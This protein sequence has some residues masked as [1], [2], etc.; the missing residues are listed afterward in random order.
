VVPVQLDGEVKPECDPTST[1]LKSLSMISSAF[2]NFA[3]NVGSL[4]N[5][6]AGSLDNIASS[7]TASLAF[8]TKTAAGFMAGT[9]I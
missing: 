4:L 6:S 1:C 9:P 7:E 2:R 8:S 5:V 3:Q